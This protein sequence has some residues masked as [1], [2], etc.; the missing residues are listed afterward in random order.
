MIFIKTKIFIINIQQDWI[1]LGI[2]YF[3]IFVLKLYYLLLQ[4]AEQLSISH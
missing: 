3:Y 4:I 1:T 2:V